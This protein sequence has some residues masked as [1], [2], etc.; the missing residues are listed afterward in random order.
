[1]ATNQSE[2]L[3]VS[4]FPTSPD[5]IAAGVGHPAGTPARLEASTTDASMTMNFLGG[6]MPQIEGEPGLVVRQAVDRLFEGWRSIVAARPAPNG[7]DSDA[8]LTSNWLR[9]AR[10]EVAAVK[11]WTNR[12]LAEIEKEAGRLGKVTS[13]LPE[14]AAE[15]PE[16]R[17]YVRN[18]P[19]ERA[20]QKFLEDAIAAGDAGTLGSV[21]QAKPYLSGIG[22][23]EAT[24]LRELWSRSGWPEEN[25]GLERLERAREM[26]ERALRVLSEHVAR[27]VEAR[28][29]PKAKAAAEAE[30]AA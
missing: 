1:M 16:I 29:E 14:P 20:R 30:R 23:A 8:R 13:Q 19:D 26:V 9:T 17:A 28:L 2:R 5:P 11:V 18:L 4:P 15:G 3:G 10:G 25:A 6:L 12:A 27:Y 24:R 21:L 7:I 22:T